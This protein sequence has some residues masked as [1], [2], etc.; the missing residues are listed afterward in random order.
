MTIFD[1]ATAVTRRGDGVYDA[2]PDR[3]F[4][5]VAP[6]GTAPPAVNGGVMIATVLRAVL[7]CSPLPHP[8]ATS[9]HF[10][11]VAKVAPA[12]IHVSWLKTGRTAATARATLIQESKPVLETTVTTGTVPASLPAPVPTGV[13]SVG[14]T[15]TGVTGAGV[16]GRAATAA[17][18]ADHARVFEADGAPARAAENGELIWTGAPPAL[19]PI[20]D[21]VDLGPWRGTVAEDGTA[22]YAGQVRMLL[23]PAVTGWARR[24]PSGLPEMRGYFGLRE[25]R[26]PD[27][28]L[29]A[30]AVD[31]MPP[32]VFGLGATG[33]APT[34]ELTMHMR[35]VPSPGPLRVA[36]RSRHVGGGWFDEEAEVW[37]AADNL[38]AQSRQIARVG[39]GPVRGL[40]ATERS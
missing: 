11:R 24:E 20:E 32:V 40:S 31:G 1:D 22:G 28:L 34:V 9:A 29:L 2:H 12:E 13:A 19:P 16:M 39:R 7:D 18:F 21:C 4:A 36:A 8:V 33:W 30:L 5:I 14:V 6:G 15:G 23:D 26:D 25:D 17:G 38:V 37:D 10:L 35:R 27:A 3:R